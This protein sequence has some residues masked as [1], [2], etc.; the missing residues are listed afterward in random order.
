MAPSCYCPDLSMICFCE[1]R[2]DNG[3][4]IRVVD[5]HHMNEDPDQAFHLNSDPGSILSLHG[6]ILSL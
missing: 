6:S 1:T 3:A 5:P 2:I 4:G